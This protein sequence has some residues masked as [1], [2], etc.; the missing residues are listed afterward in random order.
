MT[1]YDHKGKAKNDLA[2]KALPYASQVGEVMSFTPYEM[3]HKPV[4][5]YRVK[6][7]DG[8]ILQLIEDCLMQVK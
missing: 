6:A 2:R 1:L 3:G 8:T 5:V 4:I 7:E